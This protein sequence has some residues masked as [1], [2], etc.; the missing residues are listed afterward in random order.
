MH[1]WFHNLGNYGVGACGRRC[2][3]GY[4][5][6]ENLKCDGIS[7]CSDSSDEDACPGNLFSLFLYRYRVFKQQVVFFDPYPDQTSVNQNA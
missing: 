4:C 5:I 3:E 1:N 7:H 2:P 6:Q